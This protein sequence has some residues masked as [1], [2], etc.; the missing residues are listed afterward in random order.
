MSEALQAVK[1]LVKQGELLAAW[2]QLVALARPDDDFSTQHTYARLFLKIL[3]ALDQLEPL[4]IG[5][6]ASSTVDHFADVF[7]FWMAAGGFDA[8]LHLAEF[9]TIDQTLLDPASSL[10]EF[11]PDVI[12]IFSSSRDLK[13]QIPAGAGWDE[14]ERQAAELAGR[15]SN[16]WEAIA[17]NSRAHIVQNN[18]DLPVHRVFGNFEAQAAWSTRQLGLAFNRELA[19][20]AHGGV[21]IFDLDYVSGIFGKRQWF[22]DRYWF[23]SKHAFSLNASG[24]VAFQAAGVLRGL[25]GRAKKCLVLDL[26]NT[27]WGGVIGDDGVEGIRLGNGADGEAFVEFQ[28]Y[29]LAL[30]N[31]GIV[32]AVCSKNE[33]A[34]AR[35]PFRN[36]PDMV[37]KESDIAVFTANWNNKAD[38]IRDIAR[39][40][41]LGLDSFVFVD[42]NPAERELVREFLPMVA[43]PEMPEDPADYVRT[44]DACCHFETVAFSDEDRARSEMYRENAARQQLQETHTD[45]AAYLRA[46]DMK[47]AV[48]TFDSFHLPRIA[49]LINK[50]NQFH[51]TTTRY[52]ENELRAMAASPDFI[53]L[54]FKLRDRFGDSGLISVVILRRGEGDAWLV[55]TWVMS[56]RVLS[57]T[58][59]AFVH[60]TVVAA[61]RERGAISL[62]GR[63]IPTSKNGLVRDHFKS[64][65]YTQ[66]PDDGTSSLW[67]LD[68]AEVPTLGTHVTREE[69]TN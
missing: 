7:R 8:K 30:K 21:T 31:R 1:N 57:R 3:P 26:D 24:L 20:R 67:K 45:I 59:E 12:W 25:K 9:D 23:H 50:S 51:L 22:E 15:Y 28:H 52:P 13:T 10:Y 39:V 32:L 6:V 35:L 66:L 29:V 38:N 27:L 61:A 64:L 63:Y 2:P 58:M 47:S 16:L 11:K 18:A 33:D 36:H 17:R 53:T 41:N 40:L 14:T 4:K 56:C 19:R 34:N 46:L 37:L 68:L 55:D 5:I 69:P 54:Y 49:Q 44:L 60:N 42:D 62:T 43:V 48:G 65:G